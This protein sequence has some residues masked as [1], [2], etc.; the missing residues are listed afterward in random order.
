MSLFTALEDK[1]TQLDAFIKLSSCA[2]LK[3]ALHEVYHVDFPDK[4]PSISL[5]EVY[6]EVKGIQTEFE[7]TNNEREKGL[8]ILSDAIKNLR[9]NFFYKTN[10]LKEGSIE[11]AKRFKEI[12]HTKSEIE[13]THKFALNYNK[14]LIEVLQEWDFYRQQ[15]VNNNIIKHNEKLQSKFEETLGSRN[16]NLFDYLKDRINGVQPPVSLKSI[17]LG[18]MSYLDYES[19]K[20][21]TTQ[22]QRL[23]NVSQDYSR[24]AELRNEGKSIEEAGNALKL[25]NDEI[26]TIEKAYQ[27]NGHKEQPSLKYISAQMSDINS[28]LKNTAEIKL[29]KDLGFGYDATLNDVINKSSQN[30]N[31][32][33]SSMGQK[34]FMKYFALIGDTIRQQGFS[35]EVTLVEKDGKNMMELNLVM[36]SGTPAGININFEIEYKENSSKG[37]DKNKIIDI[38]KSN[39][40]NLTDKYSKGD[41]G[42]Y[43]FQYEKANLDAHFKDKIE[44]YN[45]KDH[46]IEQLTDVKFDS[47]TF[48]DKPIGKAEILNIPEI[49]S[50]ISALNKTMRN[51]ICNQLGLKYKDGQIIDKPKFGMNDI[52]I[53][54]I[55][56]NTVNILDRNYEKAKE[57]KSSNSVEKEDK[58]DFGDR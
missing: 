50:L 43:E 58:E 29:A 19:A 37:E 53:N 24:F 54:N 35:S 8:N 16:V 34:T 5:E 48:C 52:K 42:Y 26:L 9:D 46:T 23:Y 51:T 31:D 10:Q 55:L 4:N 1:Y 2:G 47:I 39:L 32:I 6:N 18:K 27:E 14:G 20:Q 38:Y 15:Q 11:F 12:L 36:D 7:N 41:I 28:K 25:N 21:I 30:I 3:A 33:R 13:Q 56:Q 22:S 17:I 49:N 45:N 57:D 40:K 44:N